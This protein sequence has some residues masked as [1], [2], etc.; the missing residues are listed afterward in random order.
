MEGTDDFST[1]IHYEHSILFF[2]M[3]EFVVETLIG[4]FLFCTVRK[5][6]GHN[7]TLKHF[8]YHM[9]TL[10]TNTKLS[11]SYAQSVYVKRAES[12]VGDLLFIMIKMG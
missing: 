11:H 2:C 1:V 7:M 3:R 9:F 8:V 10:W 5:T 4:V 6:I 12:S